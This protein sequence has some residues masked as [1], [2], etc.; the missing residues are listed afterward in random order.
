MN[1]RKLKQFSNAVEAAQATFRAE[2]EKIAAQAREEIL[3]Y[4]RRHNFDYR[5]GNGTWFISKPSA[6]AAPYFRP[7]D[8]VE[9]DDLPSNIRDLLTL[10]V[11]HGQC[12]GY[13]IADIK[14]GE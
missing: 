9:D 5:A 14:R 6:D 3:P 7:A 11:E 4:F 10:E 13:F 12:L 2:I 8:H 1:K